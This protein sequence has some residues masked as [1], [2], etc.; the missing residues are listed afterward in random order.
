MSQL[1]DY[2]VVAGNL[3]R[4]DEFIAYLLAGLDGDYNS[5]FTSVVSRADAIAPTELYA[6]LMRFEQHTSLQGHSVH[7]SSLSAMT[8]SCGHGSL[9]GRGPG[10]SS[11]GH[12]RG[13]RRTQHGGLS[14]QSGHSAGTSSNS[15]MTWP[16]C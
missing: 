8:S 6:Q 11:R 13:H 2:L 7:G 3:L 4:D 10:P 1:V 5:V 14:N 9:G 15:S 16:Q 12:G